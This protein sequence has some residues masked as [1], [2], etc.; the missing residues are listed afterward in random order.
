MAKKTDKKIQKN[1]SKTKK[2]KQKKKSIYLTLIITI[3]ILSTIAYIFYTYKD[4][5]SESLLDESLIVARINGKEI[6]LKELNE[7]YDRLSDQ[8]KTMV[9]KEDILDETVTEILLLQEAEKQGITATKE[10]ATKMISDA[11]IQGGISEEEFQEQLDSLKISKDY[12]VEYYKK[13]LIISELLNTT[14]FKELIVSY[15]EIKQFYEK[16]QLSLQ[17][18]TLDDSKD[19]IQDLLLSD[20]QKSAYLTYISQ[21]KVRADIEIFLDNPITKTQP[22]AANIFEE[23]GDS[24]CTKENK[25]IIR[26]YTTTDCQSCK[27]V[28]ETFDSFAEEY[29]EQDK[30]VAYHW[31]LNTGDNTLT[32][33]TERG[34]PM[35]EL[36]IFKKYNPKSTVPTFVF[37]CKY[38]RIG[39]AYEDQNDLNTEKQEFEKI[40]NMLIT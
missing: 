31:E 33:E 2:T 4:I 21:L 29:Q 19:E 30:I 38:M 20:K 15:T 27:W 17:N 5:F 11:M 40:T 8:Y 34:I 32:E 24:I 12:L 25:P 9:T 23:T 22:E 35:S 3:I 16:N 36:D 14:L 18:I 28:K 7:A 13:Q 6:S 37:G 26:L 1:N 10:E 39:N